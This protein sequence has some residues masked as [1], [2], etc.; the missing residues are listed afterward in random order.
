MRASVLYYAPEE[1]HAHKNESPA[2]DTERRVSSNI[3]GVE[4][5]E[6]PPEADDQPE[7]PERRAPC[8]SSV[9]VRGQ[10]LH[11]GNHQGQT[12]AVHGTYSYGETERGRAREERRERRPDAAT[13]CDDGPPGVKLA[14]DPGQRGRQGLHERPGK[15]YV[16]QL[17][18]SRGEGGAHS[19][20]LANERARGRVSGRRSGIKGEFQHVPAQAVSAR[21]TSPV[22]RQR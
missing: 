13:N 21:H 6:H 19:R 20:V 15:S 11:A 12:Q 18:G 16:S 7:G 8:F 17:R 1:A 14:A 4:R 22:W 10:A 3:R 9:Q 5:A 2:I